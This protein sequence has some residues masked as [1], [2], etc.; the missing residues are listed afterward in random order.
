MARFRRVADRFNLGAP[1]SVPE[2]RPG[3]LSRVPGPSRSS[4]PWSLFLNVFRRLFVLFYCYCG[5]DA[6]LRWLQRH[7]CVVLAYHGVV[8]PG[9]EAEVDREGK[10]VLEEDFIRQVTFISRHY[11]CVT[12]DQFQASLNG[13][14]PLPPRALL[15][16]IDDGYEHTM[17]R[18]LPHMRARRVPGVIFVVT[19][20]IGTGETPWPNQVELWWSRRMAGD[21]AGQPWPDG[22]PVELKTVKRLLKIM[23][24]KER[25]ATLKAWVG[26][27]NGG[28]PKGHPFRML[29]WEQARALEAGGMAVASHSVTHAIMAGCDD[30]HARW[31]LTES[32]AMLERELLHDVTAFAYPNGEREFFL[33]R[34]ESLLEEQGYT[35]AF[36]MI[37]GH[38][39]PGDPRMRIRRI[40]VGRPEGW[41]PLFVAR[42]SFPYELKA[43]LTGRNDSAPGYS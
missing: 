3:S 20:M 5:I 14:P 1:V 42:L 19:G 41:L 43:W 16:T 39:R 21:A 30:E 35:T 26:D 36:T 18:I 9:A 22:M 27:P 33:N 31:E 24:E 10:F 17:N 7:Q 25:T 23:P 4:P 29:D 40:A 13:G 34:D 28:L 12:L 11:R 37:Q 6:L 2:S 15:L 32:R 8:A 38:H